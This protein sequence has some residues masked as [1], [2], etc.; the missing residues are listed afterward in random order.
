MVVMLIVTSRETTEVDTQGTQALTN[1]LTGGT[2]QPDNLSGTPL[3][4]WFVATDGSQIASDPQSQSEQ[5]PI[6]SLADQDLPGFLESA[7]AS[8]RTVSAAS[9]DF[10]SHR[11]RHH[12]DHY[13]AQVGTDPATGLPIGEQFTLVRMIIGQS[14]SG[15]TSAE[16]NLILAE[17]IVGPI[18]P[19]AV[20]L[21]PA[22]GRRVAAPIEQARVRQTEFTAHAS[23]QLRPRAGDRGPDLPRPRRAARRGRDR[24]AL[25]RVQDERARI[26]GLVQDR[27]ARAAASPAT[28]RPPSTWD[29]GRRHRA[30]CESTARGAP[31]HRPPPRPAGSPAGADAPGQPTWLA[32]A[33]PEWLHGAS[34]V[35]LDNAC[36]STRRRAAP[37]MWP[38]GPR[39]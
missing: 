26:R 6:A 5:C 22:I 3:W 30:C 38:S 10:R 17:A 16:G 15:I 4:Y 12:P 25:Q 13:D 19:L 28:A 35:L 14:L 2:P 23:H 1:S 24:A 34:G 27:L 31:V 29:S 32:H 20:F 7:G 21:A 37:S 39:T 8:P 18:P 11:H 9:G 33:P 36:T